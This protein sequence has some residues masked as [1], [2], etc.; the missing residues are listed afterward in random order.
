MEI[1]PSSTE[2][3]PAKA[4]PADD[5]PAQAETVAQ[6]APSTEAAPQS[7]PAQTASAEAAP[8][9]ETAAAAAQPA[10]PETPPP[11]AA[12]AMPHAET[13]AAAPSLTAT[14]AST[15]PLPTPAP[16]RE[17]RATVADDAAPVP[18]QP[19]PA[20]PAMSSAALDKMIGQMLLVGFRGLTPEEAW[21]Q[22]LAAQL[23]AGTIGGVLFMSHNIQSPQQ[24]KTLTGFLGRAKGDIPALFAVDQEG[25]I[26]QRLSAEKGFQSYPTAG[27]IGKSNDPLTAYSVYGRL[28]AEL[29]H[30]GFNMNLGPVVDLDRNDKSPIIAGKERSFGP[31]P[32]HVA[33][34]AKA[35]CIAHQDA[36][37]L[38]VLKHFPG[39]GST[40][41]DTHEAP[42]DTGPHWDQ[43]EL[44]P[45]NELIASK[46]A[47]AVMV[48]H[49]SNQLMSE[50]PGLPAS[51]SSRT[52]RDVLRK[53]LGFSGVVI[54]DD[55][56]MGAI[57]ARYGLEESAVK[58]LKAGNDMIILSNQNA[59][60]P[61]LPERIVAAVRKAVEDGTLSREELTAS[62]ERILALK[63]RLPGATAKSG[64]AAKRASADRKTPR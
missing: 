14:D 38:T 19:V 16:I 26:V 31:Q 22:K 42:V 63:Q 51:L 53:A 3:T 62:Y 21:P 29:V 54:S 40:P 35:F 34:F 28:A 33:A 37:V 2:D 7:E 48:G 5:A 11:A 32:K 9:P 30:F 15:A 52:I 41:F 64:S 8:Q 24:L 18:R 6:P 50:E 1:A 47:Q 36:G 59:P 10:S 58:A 46:T 13:V 23:R 56:E 4:E 25:G 43:A 49:I 57:R 39:H 44:E 27:K 20:A 12:P 61:D 17:A 55:L 45:Y 60:A